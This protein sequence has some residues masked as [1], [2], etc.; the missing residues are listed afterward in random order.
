M[1]TLFIHFISNNLFF[2]PFVAKSSHTKKHLTQ[3]NH[4][5]SHYCPIIIIA[6]NASIYTSLVLKLPMMIMVMILE[7]VFFRRLQVA[8]LL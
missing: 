2:S 8:L 7:L 1:I 4:L 6:Q 5:H 3:L